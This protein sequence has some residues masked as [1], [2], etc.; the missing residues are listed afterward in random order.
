MKK[1]LLFIG[2]CFVAISCTKENF[3]DTGLA[4]GDHDCSMLEYMRGDHYNWDS[5]VVMIEHA[6]LTD[7][8]EGKTL[9]TP[10]LLSSG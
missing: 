10:N 8:F 4:N 3:I 7:L 6:G 2:V 5:T 9:I 1:I